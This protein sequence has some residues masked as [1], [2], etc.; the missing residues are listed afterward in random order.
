MARDLPASTRDQ[1][2][3]TMAGAEVAGDPA[4]AMMSPD[5][6]RALWPWIG[7]L[8]RLVDGDTGWDIIVDPSLGPNVIAADHGTAVIRCGDREHLRAMLKA[9]AA[10]FAAELE[11]TRAAAAARKLERLPAALPPVARPAIGAPE[12]I[13]GRVDDVLP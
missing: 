2:V 7:D 3:D 8:D 12:P 5:T 4:V 11:Q 10:R 13:L 1:L 9:E 6:L